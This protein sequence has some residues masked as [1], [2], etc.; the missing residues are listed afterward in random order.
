[1]FC[2]HTCGIEKTTSKREFLAF[3]FYHV[4]TGGLIQVVWLDSGCCFHLSHQCH[5]FLKIF[6]KKTSTFKNQTIQIPI[7]FAAI[8]HFDGLRALQI[9]ND[10]ISFICEFYSSTF[11]EGH[12][13]QV[14]FGHHFA[15]HVYNLQFKPNYK[16]Q[17]RHLNIWKF[18]PCLYICVTIHL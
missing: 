15:S 16:S 4:G 9:V 14:F 7:N 13:S 10:F 8:Q 12:D 11:R 1:M 17:C 3:S 5:F 18:L 2:V 6:P